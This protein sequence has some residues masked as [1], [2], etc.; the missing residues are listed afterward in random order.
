MAVENDFVFSGADGVGVDR[1]E[2]CGQMR[3][4]RVLD[5]CDAADFIMSNCRELVIA[6][7]RDDFLTFVRR[8]HSAVRTEQ[9]DAVVRSRIV[10]GRNLNAGRRF[11]FANQNLLLPGASPR[12]PEVFLA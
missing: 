9:F 5:V 3:T 8:D 10:A 2:Y 11:V 6:V 7:G 12:T 1:G 4:G